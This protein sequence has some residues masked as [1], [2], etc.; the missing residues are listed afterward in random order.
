MT[1]KPQIFYKYHKINDNLFSLL[2]NRTFWFSPQNDLNDPYDCKYS[3]SDK[4][5]SSLHRKSCNAL[6]KDLKEKNPEMVGITEDGFFEMMLPTL[7]NEDWMNGFHNLLFNDGL[8]WCVCCFTTD[9]LNELM[10]AHYADSYNGV[11]LEFNLSKTAYLHEKI[12]PI[13]YNDTFH[14]INSVEELPEV[15]LTKRTVWTYE[16]EWRVL[17]NVKGAKAFDTNSLVSIIFGYKV[18]KE[19]I[20]SIRQLMIESGY[21]NV[22]FKQMGYF[23]NNFKY[24]QIEEFPFNSDKR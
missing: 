13:K 17:S 18:K 6:F 11:C 9:P 20:D 3:L 19:T 7:K 1:D 4:Y 21:A 14:L 16:K 5:L 12:F 8:G 22:K 24:K 2:K 23:I 10:W 15:L